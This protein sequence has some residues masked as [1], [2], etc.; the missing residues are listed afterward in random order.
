MSLSVDGFISP[1][2]SQSTDTSK[3]RASF[4]A[5]SADGIQDMIPT[6][7]S[8]AR[9]VISALAAIPLSVKSM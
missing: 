3:I 4:T 2:I 5:T 1:V 8:K 9:F 6:Q 7:E